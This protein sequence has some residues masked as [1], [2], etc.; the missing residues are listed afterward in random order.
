MD[1][2]IFIVFI[3]LLSLANLFDLLQYLESLVFY[4]NFDYVYFLRAAVVLIL[5]VKQ[6]FEVIILAFP[7]SWR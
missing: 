5:N 4:L 6:I 3:M 2:P 1:L 7:E